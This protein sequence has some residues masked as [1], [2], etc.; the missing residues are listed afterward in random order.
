MLGIF[1]FYLLCG[2][3]YEFLFRHIFETQIHIQAQI[4]K[5]FILALETNEFP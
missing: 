4:L 2:K 3:N 5:T 1:L